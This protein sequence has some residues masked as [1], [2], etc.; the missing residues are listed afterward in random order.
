[1]RLISSTGRQRKRPRAAFRTPAGVPLP[2]RRCFAALLLL[3][4]GTGPG[5]AG[6]VSP[7][8]SQ[9]PRAV[10]AYRNPAATPPDVPACARVPDERFARAVLVGDSIA[11]GLVLHSLTP[12][13]TLLTRIGLSPRRARTEALYKNDGKPVTLDRKLRAMRPDAVYLWL[14]SNGLDTGDAD[15]ILADYARLLDRLLAALPETP[16]YLLEVT[17]VTALD[18]PRYDGFTNERIDRFNAGLREIAGARGLYVLR[19]NALLTD[20]NGMLAGEYA[21]E[22]GIHL[23]EAAYRLIAEYLYTHV[24]P[25]LPEPVPTDAA[26]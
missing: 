21:A 1:M 5:F 25:P 10:S 17:P 20:E 22:D 23:R 2:L 9:A 3:L 24:L 26:Q 8:P 4:L 14:G 19:T 15:S 13:L 12:T 11:D 16:L 6:A 18:S 7:A